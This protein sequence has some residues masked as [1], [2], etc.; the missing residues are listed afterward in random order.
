MATTPISRSAA[1]KDYDSEDLA[2][3]PNWQWERVA[4][5]MERSSILI[6]AFWSQYHETAR[7]SNPFGIPP[8]LNGGENCGAFCVSFISALKG[9]NPKAVLPHCRG[10]TTADTVINKYFK[11][12]IPEDQVPFI[13]YEQGR[14][15]FEQF[16]DVIRK[17]SPD[18][19]IIQ[20]ISDPAVYASQNG[21][22]R[23]GAGN[24]WIVVFQI[25]LQGKDIK[26]AIISV[27]DPIDAKIYRPTVESCAKFFENPDV[28][29]EQFIKIIDTSAESPDEYPTFKDNTKRVKHQ[30]SEVLKELDLEPLPNNGQDANYRSRT[31]GGLGGMPPTTVR[32]SGMPGTVRKSG[33]S[34][35]VRKI[36]PPVT[37]RKS[38]MSPDQGSPNDGSIR[39]VMNFNSPAPSPKS[40]LSHEMNAL[41]IN[42][43]EPTSRMTSRYTRR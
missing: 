14:V 41:N 26:K 36:V 42:P 3:P 43:N 25:E 11:K 33:M 22:K 21:M 16:L 9:W 28:E 27:W 24:H 2:T 15:N 29:G 12:I 5:Q 7:Y 10:L 32:K 1:K 19:P 34:G 13:K 38:V 37:V 17:V 18:E 23:S 40:S 35:T 39:K 31:Q 20:G 4:P 30:L 6:P 8:Q